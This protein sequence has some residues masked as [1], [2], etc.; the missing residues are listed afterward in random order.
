TFD[1]R[2]GQLESVVRSGEKKRKLSWKKTLFSWALKNTDLITCVSKALGEEIQQHHIPINKYV[3]TTPGV[4]KKEVGAEQIRHFRR[5]HQLDGS[6]PLICI[7]SVLS[8]E[9]KVKGIEILCKAFAQILQRYPEGKLLIVGDGNFKD[10]LEQLIEKLGV[11]RQVVFCGSM[12]NPFIALAVVDIYSHISLQEGLPHAIM[13][14]MLCGKPVV[15]ANIGGIPEIVIPQETGILV[16]PCEQKVA[17]AL[18]FLLNNPDEAAR[19][20]KKGEEF[21]CQ[22]FLSH[23][24]VKKVIKIYEHLL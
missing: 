4:Q 5:I 11:Q 17:E 2:P 14:A 21:V 12:D 15:A 20:G 6:Y 18:L 13:E 3:V 16:E 19:L 23:H 8:W 10:Y 1:R 7:I 24:V 9:L 22:R